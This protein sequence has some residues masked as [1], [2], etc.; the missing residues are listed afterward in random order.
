MTRP[1]A[2]RDGFLGREGYDGGALVDVID[3][4]GLSQEEGDSGDGLDIQRTVVVKISFEFL[5]RGPGAVD[6]PTLGIS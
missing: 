1:M 3:Q 2:Y 5:P 4:V 6:K